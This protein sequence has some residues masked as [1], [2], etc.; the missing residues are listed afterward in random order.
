MSPIRLIFNVISS[1]LD[2]LN[3]FS[4]NFI[5]TRIIN[6]LIDILDYLNPTSDNFIGTRIV[7]LFREMFSAIFIPSSDYFSSQY[8]DISDRLDNKIHFRQHYQ[9]LSD[10]NEN[11]TQGGQVNLDTY[12]ELP[13][14][15]IA[16]GLSVSRT[17]FIDFSVLNPYRDTWFAWCRVVFYIMIVIYNISQALKFLNGHS[18]V[19]G[20]NRIDGVS[21]GGKHTE[22]VGKH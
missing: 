19:E 18:V 5:L 1:I 13:E 15:R 16:E 6:F 21:S 3:P 8:S 9:A 7:W 20:S 12:V 4:E 2:F 14:Y 10:I 22:G 17:R 11:F